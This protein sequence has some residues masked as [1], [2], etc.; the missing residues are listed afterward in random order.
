MYLLLKL[1]HYDLSNYYFLIS[2]TKLMG[3][4]IEGQRIG[5]TTTKVPQ[6]F[7]LFCFYSSTRLMDCGTLLSYFVDVKL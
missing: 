3:L 4:F 7:N 6:L 5:D 2:E 1:K